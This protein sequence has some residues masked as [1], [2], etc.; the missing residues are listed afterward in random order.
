MNWQP[1]ETAPTDGTTILLATKNLMFMGRWDR[2]PGADFKAWVIVPVSE[3]SL[4]FP[5]AKYWMP[6]PES[7][8]E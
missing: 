1:I 5:G 7:P 8:K 4:Y 2:K 6:L 3:N